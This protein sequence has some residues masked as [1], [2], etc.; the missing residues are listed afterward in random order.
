MAQTPPPWLDALMGP[1]AYPVEVSR[2]EL[3]QT[4]ISWVFI[5]DTM[6]FKLKKPVDFGF[7][8]FTTLEKRRH[9]CQEEVRLN[10]RLC[11]T[12][13]KGVWTVVRAE[14]GSFRMVEE[15]GRSQVVEWAVAMERMDT[16][17]IM[18][19]LIEEGRL[20]WNHLSKVVERLVPFYRDAAGG[21]E[22]E[23]YGELEAVR[24][25]T[26][27][28]FEQ[29]R[30]FIGKLIDHDTFTA[31]N[32]FTDRYYRER[33]DFFE[34]RIKKGMIRDG[35]GD[36]YSANICF[37]QA[38]DQVFIFDCIEF[39]RRFRCGDWASD[40]AFLAMDLD[41][42]GLPHLSRRFVQELAAGLDDPGMDEII[43]FYKCYRAY[44]RGKIG[45]FTWAAPG[46]ADE[47]R[48]RWA[49]Q[50][51][52]YFRLAL[53]YAGGMEKRPTLY[54][55]MGPSGTGKSTVARVLGERLGVPVFNSDQVRKEI[56]A[57]IP[58][59]ER[60]IEPL[61]QGIYSEEMSIR[62]Y[63]LLHQQAAARLMTG[64]DAIIDA[65]YTSSERRREVA[66][67]A[68]AAGARL[69]AILC[70]APDEVV[71]RR[72]EERFKQGSVSDGRWEIYLAQRPAFQEV[73]EFSRVERLDTTG[74]PD[75]LVERLMEAD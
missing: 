72:L 32:E 12:I 61:G 73:S 5:T 30:E 8:D 9:F 70:T 17:G 28:N 54:I 15:P 47:E 45:C 16:R 2:V 21:P 29:T 63:R 38:K 31:I 67:V 58:G 22:V 60:R 75:S 13:Y 27:E 18:S 57:G 40:A 10:R 52:H 59:S 49:A 1:E 35:H 11:P 56:V 6:V 44:V 69:R 19:A 36:L 23:R 48:E 66:D 33:A 14:D 71:R 34:E 65:T 51:R 4:H 7:L 50:A 20:G 26:D 37:D 46:I 3:V 39:N 68:Q 53:R 41:F 62:T 74:E 43:P 55:L 64:E 25:N 42:H 24:F